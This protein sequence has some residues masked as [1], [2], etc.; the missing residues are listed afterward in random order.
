MKHKALSLDCNKHSVFL[1]NYHLVMV[2]KYRRQAITD[3]ISERL[4]SIFADIGK[5]YKITIDTWNHDKDHVHVLFRGEP[6]TELTK[7]I[8]AYKSA[9]SRLIKKE[10]PE[11]RKMLWKEAFWSQSFCL[12]TTG[13][14]PLEVI[15]KYIETQGERN[16]EG[17]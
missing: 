16:A 15:R 7:F 6:K 13:G 4:K 3:P 10:F 11:I 1:L 9:S 17:V 12:L 2:V 14:A 5:D 8:N